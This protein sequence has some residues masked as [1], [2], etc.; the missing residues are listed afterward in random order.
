[1]LSYL[2]FIEE[3]KRDQ[4]GLTVFQKINVAVKRTKDLYRG[5]TAAVSEDEAKKHK[6]S[7]IALYEIS[8]DLIQPR[9]R[10]KVEVDE[11]SDKEDMDYKEN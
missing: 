3:H 9:I 5:R 1:M 11:E 4:E 2:N 6:H 10:T 8:N 7:V